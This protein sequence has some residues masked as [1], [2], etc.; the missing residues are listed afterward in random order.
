M[1]KQRAAEK[2]RRVQRGKERAAQ[3]LGATQEK[4]KLYEDT[5]EENVPVPE[6]EPATSDL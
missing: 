5:L 6:F 1:L 2:D 4:K 3:N